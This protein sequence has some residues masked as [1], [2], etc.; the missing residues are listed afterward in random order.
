MDDA[1]SSEEEIALSITC[2]E[3]VLLQILIMEA[4]DIRMARLI[5]LLKIQ[6][7]TQD[8]LAQLNEL[9]RASDVY[10][11]LGPKITAAVDMVL[12]I[13]KLGSGMPK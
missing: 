5:E 12:E 6:K 3:M 13:D 4:M 10:M 1:G 9:S 2:V 7:L 8:E 11:S